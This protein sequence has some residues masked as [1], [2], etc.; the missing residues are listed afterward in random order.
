M[1]LTSYMIAEM[2]NH[3]SYGEIA[4]SSIYRA[5][6]VMLSDFLGM[7]LQTY[8]SQYGILYNETF[9]TIGS[10]FYIDIPLLTACPCR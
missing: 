8:S 5:T 10:N 7:Y 3:H 6:I 9:Q 4:S 1:Q 2:I